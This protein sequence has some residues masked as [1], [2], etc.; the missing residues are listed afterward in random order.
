MGVDYDDTFS[1]VVKP[2]TIR[3]VIALSIS[4]RWTMRQLDVKNAYL[5]GN[6]KKTMYMEQPQGFINPTL[7][8]HVCLLKKSLYGLKQAPRAWFDKLY[9]SCSVLV[10]IAA[11]L[12]LPCLSIGPAMLLQCFLCTSSMFFFQHT[13]NDGFLFYLVAQLGSEFAIKDLGGL[14]YLGVEIKFFPGCVLVITK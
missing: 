12:I 5:Y 9:N 6:L 2:T 14:H 11:K 10:F 3:L 4:F 13:I 1:L 7:P 8:D